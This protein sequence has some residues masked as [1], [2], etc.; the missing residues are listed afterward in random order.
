MLV[1]IN[2]RGLFM[3]HSLHKKIQLTAD[4]WHS[5]SCYQSDIDS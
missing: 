3:R 1:I 4:T 2:M 5:N